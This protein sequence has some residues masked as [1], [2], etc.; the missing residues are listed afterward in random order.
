MFCMFAI[1]E[2]IS[3]FPFSRAV[4]AAL[5]AVLA[6]YAACKSSML[7]FGHFGIVAVLFMHVSR[8]KVSVLEDRKGVSHASSSV[9]SL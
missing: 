5:A 9:Y 2:R 1:I 4:F 6:W 8:R 3:S 7:P